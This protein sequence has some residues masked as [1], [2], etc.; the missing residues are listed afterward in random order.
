MRPVKTDSPATARTIYMT[1]EE[2]PERWEEIEAIF[3]R[4]AVWKGS[5]DKYADSTKRKRGTAEVDTAFLDEIEDWRNKLARNLALRNPELSQ[6]ELNVAVQK[7]IDRIIFLRMCEDR[8]IG[9]WSK[10]SRK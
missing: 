4:E 7:T 3:S 8:G 1:F 5:F 10:T 9:P 2:Y 6:R